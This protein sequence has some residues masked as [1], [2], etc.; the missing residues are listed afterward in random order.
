MIKAAI[1]ILVL[2]AIVLAP[3]PAEARRDRPMYAGFAG[4]PSFYFD[5][6]RVHGRVQGEIGFHFT[7]EDTGFFLAIEAVPTFN[8]DNDFFMF[9]GGVRLG[10]DIELYGTRHGAVLLRPS[11]LFGF[12]ALDFPGPA[13]THA[14]AVFQ[15]ALDLRFPFAERAVAFWIRP[16]A[17]EF[18]VFIDRYFPGTRDIWWSVGMHFMLGFDFQFG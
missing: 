2:S 1:P 16:P 5:C 17:F 9:F 11:V 7:G 14:F 13:N 12:G 15:P 18:Y 4:G 3:A 6:C 8:D 10:G